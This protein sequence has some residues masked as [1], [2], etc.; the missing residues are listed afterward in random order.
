[1][2][3]NSKIKAR[4][5]VLMAGML[6]ITATSTQLRADT[7]TCGG[8]S[9]TLPFTDVAGNPFFCA[10]AE[11]YFSGLTNGTTAT[12]YSPA[13][14]VPREQ[15]AAF[16]TR[17]LD[18]SLKRG[19]RRG[20]LEQWYSPTS[21][22]SI[23]RTAVGHA[24]NE[25]K[26]DGADLWVAN[27]NSQTV[28]RVRA[29]DGKLLET[30][31]NAPAATA[32]VVARGRVYIAGGTRPGLLY[33]I[34]PTQ[35]AGPV[36]L[37]ANTLGDFPQGI[38]FD[39]FNIWTANNSPGSVSR[40]DPVGGFVDNFTVGFAQPWGIL[41]DGANIWV[42]DRSAD[43]LLKLNSFGQIIQTVPVGSHPRGLIFDG[44][45]IWVTNDM[46]DTVTVVRASIGAVIATLSGNGL[47]TPLAAAFDGERIM[48]TNYA[49]NSV[50]LWKA[51]DLTPLGSVSTGA[52]S[53][54]HRACSDGLNFWITLA[55]PQRLARF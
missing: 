29:S 7:G 37:I 2:G 25:V 46:D 18:Q 51:A 33:E 36:T 54:P 23:A 44:T 8:V 22:T 49:G 14:N 16:V 1:M 50:S 10:I 5:A 35:P 39:G 15:M 47:S 52:N 3:A 24:P 32:V 6:I 42:T 20:A 48:V 30:W 43:T 53:F 28:S 21:S 17:T 40:I 34:N 38:A 12:T 45:N 27:F 11:A 13:N 55:G 31:T 9:T 4:A 26:S 41:Y 19:S